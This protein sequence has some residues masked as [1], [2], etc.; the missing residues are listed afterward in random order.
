MARSLRDAI[1]TQ[2]RGGSAVLAFLC[3]LALFVAQTLTLAHANSHEAAAPGHDTKT[4]VYHV[5]GDRPA[6]ALAPEAPVVS[7]PAFDGAA[8]FGCIAAQRSAERI[9]AVWA[10]GPPLKD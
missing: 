1:S 6:A 5:N 7:A 9:A 8:E 2:G 3:A 10:R 4:C